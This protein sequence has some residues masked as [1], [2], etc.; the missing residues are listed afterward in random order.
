MRALYYC[1]WF[2]E[3]T[4]DLVLAVAD[5]P[6]E[7]SVIIRDSTHEFE[8]RRHD[9]DDIHSRL[10]EQCER[11][12]TLPGGYHSKEAAL[13]IAREFFRRKNYSRYDVFHIQITY[14]PRFLWLAWRMRTVLTVHEPNP[15]IGQPEESGFRG[16]AKKGFRRLYRQLADVIVVHTESG[17]RGL[18]SRELRKAIVI[19]HGVNI[20]H[21]DD[22]HDSNTILFFG[23]VAD[24]KGIDT[25]LAAMEEVWRTRPDARL[26]ILASPGDGLC[27]RDTAV[28][29]PRIHATWYGYSKQDLDFALAE[30]RAV[31]LPYLSASGSGVG[32][33]ALGSGTPIVASNLD[34]LRELVAHVDL[35]VE[36]GSVNDLARALLAVLGTDYEPRRI[37]P[38]RTWPAVAEAH[39][40]VYQ[41]LLSGGRESGMPN[42]HRRDVR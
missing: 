5:K 8:S 14:D 33:Q 17:L 15:R 35:L 7:I 22:S 31:C 13:L 16:I 6:H 28:L 19:P 32:A 25:L 2:K 23:R 37:D 20:R 29:D 39:V 42:N 21:V 38:Q 26:R 36:P 12:V 11:V 27:G 3:Y 41:A 24:Y 4:A 40:A 1:D 18:T 10:S 30:A 9:E 34:G